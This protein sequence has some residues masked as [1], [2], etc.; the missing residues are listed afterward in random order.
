MKIDVGAD[1]PSLYVKLELRAGKIIGRS[2]HYS[3][4][5]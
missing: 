2:F 1:V 3:E 5:H 4:Y